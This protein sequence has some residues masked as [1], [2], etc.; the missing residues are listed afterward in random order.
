MPFNDH[1]TIRHLTKP[2]YTKSP[3]QKSSCRSCDCDNRGAYNASCDKV[4]GACVFL[5]VFMCV[6]HTHLNTRSMR[7]QAECGGKPVQHMCPE[8]LQSQFLIILSFILHVYYDVFQLNPKHPPHQTTLTNTLPSSNT[9]QYTTPYTT[10]SNHI[11][12]SNTPPTITQL[13]MAA[14]NVCA[15]S[16]ELQ[17]KGNSVTSSAENVDASMVWEE[18]CVSCVFLVSSTP[19]PSKRPIILRLMIILLFSV[20]T[21]VSHVIVT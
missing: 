21:I 1:T 4:T 18:P 12:L 13:N 17:T 11:T 7:M 9:H 20:L 8:L 19:P 15:T 14:P 3:Q 10:T 6:Q 2:H 16:E 5:C